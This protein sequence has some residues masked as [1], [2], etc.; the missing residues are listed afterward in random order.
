VGGA[1]EENKGGRMA[2]TFFAS[3]LCDSSPKTKTKHWKETEKIWSTG[4]CSIIFSS[5]W[6]IAQ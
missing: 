4:F 2:Q 6:V 1:E 3:S 5:I